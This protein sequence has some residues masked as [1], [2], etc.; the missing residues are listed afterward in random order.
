MNK[1]MLGLGLLI[2][3]TSIALAQTATS[4]VGLDPTSLTP[5][6]LTGVIA[7]M[8]N[9]FSSGNY[10]VGSGLLLTVAIAVFKMLGMNKLF[11]K[12]HNKW[13]AGALA[14]AT[15]VAVGLMAQASWWVIFSTGVGVGVTAI[16]GWELVLEPIMKWLKRKFPGF[17]KRLPGNVDLET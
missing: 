17:F 16:G 14:M 3:F 8:A 1:L 2:Y 7:L 9:A 5:G 11:H 12:K 6:D 15:S 13:V 10:M 4:T